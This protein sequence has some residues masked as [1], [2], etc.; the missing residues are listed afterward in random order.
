MLRSPKK[1]IMLLKNKTDW[2]LLAKYM[3][4]ETDAKEKHAVETWAEHSP[5]NRALL[6]EIKIRLEENG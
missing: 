4:G 5:E 3:A 1:E 2:S 6:H